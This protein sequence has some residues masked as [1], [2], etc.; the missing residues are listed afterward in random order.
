[1]CRRRGVRHVPSGRGAQASFYVVVGLLMA[2]VVVLAVLYALLAAP[3]GI[4]V[5]TS[6]TLRVS[7]SVQFEFMRR[8]K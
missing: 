6:A 2:Q 5:C 3:A 1:M 4:T 8:R 7:K